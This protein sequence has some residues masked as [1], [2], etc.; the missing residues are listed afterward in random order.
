MNCP[1]CNQ[2]T[3]AVRTISSG[4]AGKATERTCPNGHRW[5]YAL[6]LVGAIERRGDGPHAVAT[7]IA[8]GEN[9]VP[10]KDHAEEEK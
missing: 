1:I 2:P 4:T 8:R 6:L 7:R 5:T 9:P 10:E 3:R